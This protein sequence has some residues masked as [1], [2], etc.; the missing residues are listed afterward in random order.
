MKKKKSSC[1]VSHYAIFHYCI[2]TRRMYLYHISFPVVHFQRK[3]FAITSTFPSRWK[4]RTHAH[5]ELGVII[6]NS[7]RVLIHSASPELKRRQRGTERKKKSE[8]ESIPKR[9]LIFVRR[10]L[11]DRMRM[12][13]K[14]SVLLTYPFP[15][16]PFR[17][18]IKYHDK[19]KHRRGRRVA[20]SLLEVDVISRDLRV[21][22][23]RI[24][25]SVRIIYRAS[26]DR[27][28]RL[29]DFL[30]VD[31]PRIIPAAF[32]GSRTPLVTRVYNC[33]SVRLLVLLCRPLSFVCLFNT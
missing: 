2:R 13:G 25:A 10:I 3:A 29:R 4:D 11:P 23:E 22:R 16:A 20:I 17:K 28:S 14:R 1:D 31:F 5:R 18:S 15:S 26:R 19:N 8:T 27:K 6:P 32:A 24:S 30:P 7:F 9:T 33:W 21:F 12:T